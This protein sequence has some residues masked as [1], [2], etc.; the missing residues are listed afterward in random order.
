MFVEKFKSQESE[1]DDTASSEELRDARPTS[2]PN[3]FLEN[4]LIHDKEPQI[5]IDDVLGD[6]S[7]NIIVD[8]HHPRDPTS[9][10][11]LRWGISR[12]RK[13]AEDHKTYVPLVLRERKEDD[14][15]WH[16]F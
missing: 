5:D 8:L 3:P 16:K 1:L 9:R 13:Q 11:Q 15:Y 10:Q 7:G 12:K 6:G 2:P 14:Y 4:I